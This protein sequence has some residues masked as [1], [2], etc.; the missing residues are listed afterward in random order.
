[1]LRKALVGIG[2]ICALIGAWLVVQATATA[3][4]GAPPAHLEN[5]YRGGGVLAVGVVLIVLSLFVSPR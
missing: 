1:M 5:A 2:A 4:A 3:P